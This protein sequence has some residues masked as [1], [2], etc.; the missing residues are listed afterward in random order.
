MM[1]GLGLQPVLQ[2]MSALSNRE[3]DARPTLQPESWLVRH[4]V[5]GYRPIVFVKERRAEV[6]ERFVNGRTVLRDQLVQLSPSSDRKDE[7]PW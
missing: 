4:I 6:E 1:T 5:A 7:H 3:P 2:H